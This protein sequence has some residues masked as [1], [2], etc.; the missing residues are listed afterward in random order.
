MFESFKKLLV[1][2]GEVEH[3]TENFT[4]E[5]FC[6]FVHD[7]QKELDSIGTLYEAGGDNSKCDVCAE[8][9]KVAVDSYSTENEHL[10]EQL[11]LSMRTVNALKKDLDEAGDSILNLLVEK[12]DA[13]VPYVFQEKIDSLSISLSAAENEIIRLNRLARIAR[14]ETIRTEAQLRDAKIEIE[15]LNQ[16]GIGFNAE[17]QGNLDCI[18]GLEHAL[19]YEEYNEYEREYFR[20]LGAE[21]RQNKKE[22]EELIK[23]QEKRIKFLSDA[24]RDKTNSEG[25]KCPYL[26]GEYCGASEFMQKTQTD[27]DTANERLMHSVSEESHKLLQEA[28]NTMQL[29]ILELETKLK[30]AHDSSLPENAAE[31]IRKVKEDADKLGNSWVC[32]IDREN[33]YALINI[34]EKI[35]KNNQREDSLLENYVVSKDVD[36]IIIE[37]QDNAEISGS[38]WYAL[39]W[40]AKKTAEINQKNANLLFEINRIQNPV[41]S[42]EVEEVFV[43]MRSDL[44]DWVPEIKTIR[45][46]IENLQKALNSY[47]N[48]IPPTINLLRTAKALRED[49][50]DHDGAFWSELDEGIAEAEKAFAENKP[51]V[52][53][54]Y[55]PKDVVSWPPE[56]AIFK[57]AFPIRDKSLDAQI[58]HERGLEVIALNNE[59]LKMSKQLGL[60]KTAIEQAEKQL[61]A[62]KS[63][64]A[65]FQMES[66]SNRC[67]RLNIQNCQFCE[68]IDCG[69]NL[70]DAK[71]RISGLQS[72]I[73]NKELEIS[74]LK[75]NLADG[76]TWRKSLLEQDSR[77][78]KDIQKQDQLLEQIQNM[79][80]CQRF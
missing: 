30:E 44:V 46:T 10:K 37:A 35:S 60:E 29:R 71:V 61:A 54:D 74:E 47:R 22:T 14:A 34:A 62:A 66:M 21:E 27:L 13:K 15:R 70:S 32:S 68:D 16:E 12:N 19:K 64:I 49:Y 48:E 33:L 63:E 28:T 11:E 25:R 3:E 50:A 72:Q 80:A 77:I 40:L 67:R 38:S 17:M 39:I 36:K 58:A 56:I 41:V 1:A 55:I 6:G 23:I 76:E 24:L 52:C 2:L 73:E 59:I 78:C 53:P 9:C 42:K 65:V 31:I 7:A 45:S 20:A 8:T 51:V 79:I 18:A 75:K 57:K 4:E 69:D 43:R 5:E 26:S